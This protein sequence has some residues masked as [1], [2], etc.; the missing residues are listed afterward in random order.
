MRIA[1]ISDV[2]GN[3]EAL[4]QVFF[5]IECSDIDKTFCLGDNVGYGPEPEKVIQLIRSRNIP[6]VIGNHDLA[7]NKGGVFKQFNPT[8]QAS[9]QITIKM[10]SYDSIQYLSKLPAYLTAHECRFVHGFPPKSAMR[11]LFEVPDEEL[12]ST[13][14]QM[15]ERICFVGH[16]HEL[17]L[18]SSDGTR[19]KSTVLRKS[20]TSLRPENKYIINVGSVG[21]PR[22]GDNHAKYVVFDQSANTIEVRFVAYDISTVAE[23]IIGAGLPEAH[24]R[25]LF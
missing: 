25:R 14:N 9:L 11:Y 20:T 17:V 1:I 16:T 8:A 23:K 13:I 4:E 24:A 18:V 10:L 5:D 12:V 15:T 3:L 22:D 19:Y 6:C 21:Q 7:V 2:H